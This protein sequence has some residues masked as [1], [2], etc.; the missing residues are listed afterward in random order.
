MVSCIM[1]DKSKNITIYLNVKE[2]LEQVSSETRLALCE[3]HGVKHR[4]HLLRLVKDD[5]E[6]TG[7]KRVAK[8]L[9]KWLRDN[10]GRE[11]S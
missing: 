4:S 10:V 11:G 5:L 6:A 8:P 9:S 1:I 3:Y 7:G 2:L